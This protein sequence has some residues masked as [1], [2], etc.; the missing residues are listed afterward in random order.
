[1]THAAA[2]N[3][4]VL[5]KRFTPVSPFRKKAH[6]W[7]PLHSFFQAER[8]QDIQRKFAYEVVATADSRLGQH[9]VRP[10]FAYVVVSRYPRVVEQA[11]GEGSGIHRHLL[12]E[13]TLTPLIG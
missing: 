10:T 8:V 6:S 13:F 3:G 4:S 2:S 5:E 9:A 12:P 1:M 11:G 7:R